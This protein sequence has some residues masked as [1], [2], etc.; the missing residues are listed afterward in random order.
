MKIELMLYIF[1]M[2]IEIVMY[3]NINSILYGQLIT[4]LLMIIVIDAVYL[5]SIRYSNLIF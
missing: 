2:V 5:I 4:Y 1:N 3:H